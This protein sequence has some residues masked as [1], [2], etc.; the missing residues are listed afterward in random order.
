MEGFSYVT[1][2]AEKMYNELN[3]RNMLIPFLRYDD[4]TRKNQNRLDRLQ[5]RIIDLGLI[6][7]LHGNDDSVIKSVLN[8]KLPGEW[9]HL[10]FSIHAIV[11]DDAPDELRVKSVDL[12][13]EMFELYDRSNEDF[14]SDH[15]SNV[16]RVLRIFNNP[17]DQTVKKV[18]RVSSKYAK[19]NWD[20][21]NLIDFMEKNVVNYPRE[22]GALYVNL[23]ESTSFFPGWPE[24]KIHFICN[25]LNESR[26][27][28]YLS[29]ICRIYGERS[30]N[31][32]PIRDVCSNIKPKLT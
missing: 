13:K 14:T 11:K 32:E 1:A 27:S 6:A 16:N 22:V 31:C 23:L 20:F 4:Q 29:T 28:I 3:V 25:K 18:F 8:E 26:E 30:I 21:N 24:D 7:Y 2:Y 17:S 9:A 19:G 10:F 5:N 12:V 15:F